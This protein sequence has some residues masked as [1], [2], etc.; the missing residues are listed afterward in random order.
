MGKAFCNGF[1]WPTTL[2]D[3]AELVKS[4]EARQFHAKQIHQQAQDLQTIPLSWP[5]TV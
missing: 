1:Y 5:F 3:A 4:C 2:N